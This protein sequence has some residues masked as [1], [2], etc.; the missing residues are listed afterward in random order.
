M[1]AK[2]QASWST[3]VARNENK[4]L[5]T[6]CLISTDYEANVFLELDTETSL[7]KN[8]RWEVYRTPAGM[9]L[10]YGEISELKG[11]AVMSYST[12]LF[13][14]TL[15]TDLQGVLVELVSEA[16]RGVI[17][18]L[19]F[20]LKE[21]GYPT[22]KIFRENWCNFFLGSCIHFSTLE[23]VTSHLAEMV[24]EQLVSLRKESIFQRHKSYHIFAN[25]DGSLF[26]TAGF[27]D[28]Y[29]EIILTIAFSPGGQ[30]TEIS[31]SLLRSPSIRCCDGLELLNRLIGTNLTKLRKKEIA[32]FVGGSSG[33]THIVEMCYDLGAAL[34]ASKVT[35]LTCFEI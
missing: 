32:D 4:L 13:L 14:H 21:R 20:L 15:D 2:S 9:T 29:H 19:N 22:S 16:L 7:L 10:R 24:E 11:V 26:A 34:S 30:V 35:Q 27:A 18:S 33:C 23:Q 25:S 17:Q 3:S 12:R 31:G 5:I 28:T 1:I 6:S 8:V